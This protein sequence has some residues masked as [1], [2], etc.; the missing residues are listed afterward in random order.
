MLS[1]KNIKLY[2]TENEEKSSVV[3]RFNRTIKQ[4][5]WKMFSANNN[6]V[7]FD[8]IDEL[9]K[10]YNSSFHRSIQMS[11]LEA[12]DI[13]N[14]NRVFANLYSGEIYKQVK[15]P[16]FRIGDRVRISKYKRKLFDKGFTPNDRRNLCY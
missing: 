4:K 5:M 1:R 2:S 9:L 6:T 8:K 14:S 12:S 3:E 10:N 11:P 16:K 13:K 7:Y 15:K